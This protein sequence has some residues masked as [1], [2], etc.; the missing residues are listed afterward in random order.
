M[1]SKKTVPVSEGT[2]IIRR[3]EGEAERIVAKAALIAVIHNV[4]EEA[5]AVEMLKQIKLRL[6]MADDSR[7][8][9]V[10]PL[11]EHVKMINARFKETLKP[12]VEA[13]ARIRQGM[14]AYRNSQAFKEAQEKRLAIE[15][16]GREA[17]AAGDTDALARLTDEH[18]VA[19]AAAPR[20]VET[21]SGEARFRKVW[22][23]DSID[24]EALPAGFW[25]PDERK[26]KAAVEAGVPVPGV[27]AHVEMVPIIV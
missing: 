7:Q 1:P 10:K 18:E 27:H 5:R 14:V 12:L 16:A 26:I 2:D 25:M 4:D 3:I 21:Q 11:N 20:K 8:V 9:L 17:V 23:I 13:D 19:L 6:D 22:K 15:Q 24:L